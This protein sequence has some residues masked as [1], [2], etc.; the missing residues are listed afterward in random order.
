MKSIADKLIDT[1]KSEENKNASDEK[2]KALEQLLADIDKLGLSQKADYSFPLV[3]TIG[4]TT[5]SILN[6]PSVS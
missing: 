2:F 5:Y 1:V 4:K 6:K 3:D